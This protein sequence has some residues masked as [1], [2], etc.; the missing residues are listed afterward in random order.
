MRYRCKVGQG[1]HQ[2]H[3]GLADAE[4]HPLGCNIGDAPAWPP[5]QVDRHVSAIFQSEKLQGR[6]FSILAN[7]G[8]HPDL[9]S[10]NDHSSI[11]S[12]AGLV[13]GYGLQSV[14]IKQ[15]GTG[16]PTVRHENLAVIRDSTGHAW[17]SGQRCDVAPAVMVNHFDA[18]AGCV[19]NEDAPAL[20]IESG[21]IEGAASTAWYDDRSDRLQR[22]DGLAVLTTTGE[23]EKRKTAL[24]SSTRNLLASRVAQSLD[25]RAV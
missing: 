8:C 5:R 14:G 25:G 19:R 1:G 24:T 7:A 10:S 15:D 4:E 23:Q 16:T 21:V 22:H 18:I 6:Y 20:C 17:K 9:G 12:L 11:W 3:R 2:H 13:S